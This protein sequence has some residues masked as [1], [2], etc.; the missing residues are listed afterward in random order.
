VL[1]SSLSRAL[2]VPDAVIGAI[3]Y[4]AEAV[5][6]LIGGPT[7]A[8]TAPWIVI[9]YGAL[10]TAMAATAV[11]LVLSQAFVVHAW[12]TLCL[13]SALVSWLVFALALREAVPAIRSASAAHRAARPAERWTSRSH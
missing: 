4:A 7:R 11:A 5:L 6:L 13:G 2:P 3:A 12:C 9:A 10:A 8:R 1:T